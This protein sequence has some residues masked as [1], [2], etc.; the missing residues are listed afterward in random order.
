MI[1]NDYD[2]TRR[3]ELCG[4]CARGV[5]RS[6]GRCAR[7]AMRW[8]GDAHEGR[9]ARGRCAR[10]AMR[11]ASH[12]R[13]GM[14]ADESAMPTLG[15]VMVR[16]PLPNNMVHCATQVQ[17]V[18]HQSYKDHKRV[19]ESLGMSAGHIPSGLV[20]MSRLGNWGEQ[21]GN[22]KRD[23]L[24]TLVQRVPAQLMLPHLVLSRTHAAK[25]GRF[26]Q[27][28]FGGTYD[29]NVVQDSWKTVAKRKDSRLT[30]HPMCSA[31]VAPQVRPPTSPR[32]RRRRSASCKMAR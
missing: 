14:L 7:G 24:A 1:R 12:I 6:I 23:L 2:G 13:G 18:C 29:E 30:F 32:R 8:R 15:M 17:D 16:P 3:A 19:L 11:T 20:A 9:S 5:R 10:W 4:R 26:E 27:L 22:I 31:L 21:T 25:L 28:S